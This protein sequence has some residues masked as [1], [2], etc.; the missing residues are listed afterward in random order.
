MGKTMGK[1][2]QVTVRHSVEIALIYQKCGIRGK[3]LY[4]KYPQ[5]SRATIYWHALKQI[6]SD[7][8]NIDKPK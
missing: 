2:K 5:Y 1:V 3:K 8:N 6:S 7:I 4:G